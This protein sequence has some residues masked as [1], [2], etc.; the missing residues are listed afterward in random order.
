MLDLARANARAAGAENV[1]F[2]LGQIEAI[3]C[4]GPAA[5]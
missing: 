5:A 1:E 3:P 2:L 4:C